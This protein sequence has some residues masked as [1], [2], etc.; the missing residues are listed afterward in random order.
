MTTETG[1][2]PPSL[3]KGANEAFCSSCGN[4]INLKANVCPNCGVQRRKGADKTALALLAFFLGGFGAH[5][6]YVGKYGQGIF[7]ILFCWTGI[8]GLIAFVEFIIYLCTPSEEIAQKYTSKGAGPVIAVVACVF[9]FIFFM[10]ILAAIAIPNFIA[11]RNKATCAQVEMQANNALVALQEFY[12]DPN[13]THIPSLD[14]LVSTT[15]L[16]TNNSVSL[17]IEPNEDGILIQAVHNNA[18]CPNGESYMLSIS[19]EIVAQWQ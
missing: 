4:P 1:M 5:K 18:S 17:Y 3:P 19:D 8:P 6:F 2:Q 12:S 9:G 15:G 11:Y 7:Y 10:G 16:V 14:E 13:N